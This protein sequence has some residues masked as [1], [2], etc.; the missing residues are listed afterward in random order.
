M[1]HR[2]VVPA[3]IAVLLVLGLAA[4]G[5]KK[6]T[7]GEAATER[8]DLVLDLRVSHSPTA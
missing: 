2:R 4:C 6:E 1:T 5:E 7:T 8:V 3:M